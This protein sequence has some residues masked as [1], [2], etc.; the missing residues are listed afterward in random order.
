MCVS[1][2]VAFLKHSLPWF[3][4]PFSFSTS[5]PWSASSPDLDVLITKLWF[6]WLGAVP[7]HCRLLGCANCQ[8]SFITTLLH[9][10]DR[11]L[12]STWANLPLSL[13]VYIASRKQWNNCSTL[14][15]WLRCNEVCSYPYCLRQLCF[16]GPPT[17]FVFHERKIQVI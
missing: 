14:W 10:E 7:A 17:M 15:A 12:N 13:F 1:A 16:Y 2:T 6:C 4:V 3:L 5:C 11:K 8:V 9:I